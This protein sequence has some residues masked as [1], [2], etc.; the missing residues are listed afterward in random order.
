MEHKETKERNE[1]RASINRYDLLGDPK[2]LVLAQELIHIELLSI[3]TLHNPRLCYNG[4]KP[5]VHHKTK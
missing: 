3:I 2:D 1:I 4:C 5:C